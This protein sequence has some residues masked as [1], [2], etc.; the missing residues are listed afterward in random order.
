MSSNRSWFTQF[1][2][3]ASPIEI[4]LGDNSSIWGTRVGRISVR[5]Q[6]NG[7]WHQAT[8]GSVL[9]IPDLHGNLLSVSHLMHRGAKVRFTKEGCQIYDQQKVLIC[10]GMLWENLFFMSIHV[11]SPKSAHI[12]IAYLD[13]SPSE[14][15]DIPSKD[16]ALTAHGA[17]SRANADLWHC[18]LGHLND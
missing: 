5:M 3:L 8:L 1:T 10:E 13:T 17:A 15:E 4:V 7:K 2:P 18:H 9:Y 11:T 14:G 12:A 16:L 6:A